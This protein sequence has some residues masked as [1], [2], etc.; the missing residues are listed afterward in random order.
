LKENIND[1]HQSYRCAIAI[2]IN[3]LIDEYAEDV[4]YLE[5]YI[6]TEGAVPLSYFYQHLQ[7]YLIV[8]PVIYDIAREIDTKEV[9]GCEIID[10]IAT[11]RS[12]IPIVNV[13]LKRFLFHTRSVFLKQCLAWCLYGELDDPGQ[14]FMIQRRVKIHEHRYEDGNRVK[15]M[16]LSDE[17][18]NRL[19]S[20]PYRFDNHHSSTVDHHSE[21]ASFDWLSSY[22]LRLEYLPESQ[23]TLRLASK[24]LFCGKAVKLL[25]LSGD[26]SYR[27]RSI[28]DSSGYKDFYQYFAG[29]D[30]IVYPEANTPTKDVSDKE[31]DV[32]GFGNDQKEQLI[33]NVDDPNKTELV[34]TKHLT[35]NGFDRADVDRFAT[36][37]HLLVDRLDTSFEFLEPLM[38]DIHDVLSKNLWLWLRDEMRF[39]S[40]L[41]SM[42]S[43]YL[44]GRGEFFQILLDQVF[45]AIT[46]TSTGKSDR[47]L[48]SEVESSLSDQMQADIVLEDALE[49]TIKLLGFDEFALG[50][51]MTLQVTTSQFIFPN[52]NLPTAN[53]IGTKATLLGSARYQPSQEN[54]MMMPGGYLSLCSTNNLT[55]MKNDIED[56]Y[57]QARMIEFEDDDQLS[58][59]QS[60]DAF[61]KN[62]QAA[63]LPSEYYVN[64]GLA[65]K[66]QRYIAK[67]FTSSM[68]FSLDWIAV[69][70]KLNANH[71]CFLPVTS[72]RPFASPLRYKS[73]STPTRRMKSVCIGSLS[74]TLHNDRFG[75]QTIGS[76]AYGV[77][78]ISGSISIGV[79][80]HGKY[81]LSV[82][83]AFYQLI[84]IL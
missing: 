33:I 55:K 64:G 17:V 30:Q 61:A 51:M 36:R 53:P 68:S 12:G 83:V 48:R 76:G 11:I 10:F 13:V 45:D 27:Y 52:A 46:E 47:Y 81:K 73:Q 59:D 78:G 72:Q 42:R 35:S 38:T 84:I 8:M 74:L 62:N 67:G 25:Q 44:L 15:N 40:F 65:L 2:G 41:H 54:E 1:R 18:M 9:R 19:R 37:F 60:Q 82:D 29:K 14:E 75:S 71:S 77:D 80:I 56:A 70:A 26:E 34:V 28:L 21:Q 50:N 31:N 69:R 20:L 39:I 63:N 58:A 24:I 57:L 32:E 66:D 79:S 43:L 4:A 6:L 23:I 16:K 22:Y 7:K 3:E 5:Q 49:Y